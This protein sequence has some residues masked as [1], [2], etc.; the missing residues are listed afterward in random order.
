MIKR[1]LLVIVLGVTLSG[2]FM[3]PLALIGPAAS[4]FTTASIVQSGVTSGASYLIKQ[5]TG[6]SLSEHAIDVINK[7]VL[8]Q[9]YFPKDNTALFLAP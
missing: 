9:A 3:A 1:L 2:C 4:G 7:E 8:Q 5:S 6:K